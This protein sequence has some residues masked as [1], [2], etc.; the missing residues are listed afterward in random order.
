MRTKLCAWFGP[1]ADYGQ[2]RYL[3][4]KIQPARK[5]KN[6]R[7]AYHYEGRPGTMLSDLYCQPITEPRAHRHAK[8]LDWVCAL[9]GNC[10]AVPSVIYDP[11]GGSGTTLIAAE[12]TGHT[13]IIVERDS[14]TCDAALSRFEAEGYAIER[15]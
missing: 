15:A 4:A 1:L 7:G 13:A 3:L 9:L 6:N 2:E 5:V 8:P 10:I 11:F 14:A 12:R